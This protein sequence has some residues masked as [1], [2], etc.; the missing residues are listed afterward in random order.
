MHRATSQPSL[1]ILCV[2]DP[3]PQPT[4]ASVWNRPQRRQP[5]DYSRRAKK[6]HE[7]ESPAST[8]PHE[9]TGPRSRMLRNPRSHGPTRARALAR[10][11]AGSRG[12]QGQGVLSESI[13]VSGLGRSGFKVRPSS[14]RCSAVRVSGFGRSGCGRRPSGFRG[15]GFRGSTGHF[16]IGDSP[17]EPKGSRDQ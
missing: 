11:C 3:L 7:P 14:F 5:F 1:S 9:P 12:G 8:R 10:T 16:G 13:R 4:S 2:A 17:R 15:S 6:K